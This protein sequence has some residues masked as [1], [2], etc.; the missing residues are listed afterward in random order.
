LACESVTIV[1]PLCV[2]LLLVALLLRGCPDKVSVV[3][4]RS[5][6]V[7]PLKMG[8]NLEKKREQGLKGRL[9]TSSTCGGQEPT[10]F[11]LRVFIVVYLDLVYLVL[12]MG[13]AS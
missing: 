7:R 11:N 13:L 5:S 8:T 9:P 1:L 4:G 3:P 12:V 10:M 6:F 2:P